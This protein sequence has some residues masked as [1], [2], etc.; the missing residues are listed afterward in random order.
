MALPTKR[1][2][3]RIPKELLDM[4]DATVSILYIDRSE[5]VRQALYEKLRPYID[6]AFPGQSGINMMLTDKQLDEVADM[7]RGEKRRRNIRYWPR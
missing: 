4:V 6:N 3:I 1:L 2:E 7:V 5:F